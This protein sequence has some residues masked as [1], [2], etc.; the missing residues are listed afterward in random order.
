LP[1]KARKKA[2]SLKQKLD[3]IVLRIPIN[4]ESVTA[5]L[6]LTQQI[7]ELARVVKLPLQVEKVAT[8]DLEPVAAA[9]VEVAS[10][11]KVPT[12]PTVEEQK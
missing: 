7:I 8:L 5:A 11:I 2:E 12:V 9:H 3:A 6:L 1:G 4:V 10:E